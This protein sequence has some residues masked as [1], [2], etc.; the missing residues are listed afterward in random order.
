[1]NILISENQIQTRVSEMASEID[2][3]YYSQDWYRKTQEPVIV[4]GIL[5]GALFFVVD[6]IRKLSIRTE[7][8]FI[9]MSSYDGSKSAAHKPKVIIPP[10]RLLHDAHILLVDNVLDTGKTLVAAV[11]CLATSHPETINTSVL[12][13]KP[14]D[15]LLN[16][17]ADF[18]GFDISDTFITGY[19][20]DLDGRFRELPFIGMPG[21]SLSLKGKEHGY[22]SGKSKTG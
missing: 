5:T 12:L 10:N 9:R 19:G 2:E 14:G 13:C 6:L 18:V 11:D 17:G 16:C 15:T 22:K 21:S 20:L 4:I 1:M 8:D 7:L 3:Y